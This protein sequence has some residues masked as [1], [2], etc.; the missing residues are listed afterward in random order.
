MGYNSIKLF[1]FRVNA[2]GFLN[3]KEK[4]KAIRNIQI[5]RTLKNLKHYIGLTGFMQHLVPEYGI[6]IKPLQKKKTELLADGKEKGKTDTQ[7]K[8][9]SFVIKASFN[10]T[11]EELTAFRSI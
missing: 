11:P 1:K 8:R 10:P 2:F 6:L 7:S 5:P 9:Y 4:I 3:T